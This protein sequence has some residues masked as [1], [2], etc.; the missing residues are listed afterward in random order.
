MDRHH[1]WLLHDY[2]QLSIYHEITWKEFHDLQVPKLVSDILV[3]PIK[4][5]ALTEEIPAR[6][7]ILSICQA[8]SRKDLKTHKHEM[9]IAISGCLDVELFVLHTGWVIIDQRGTPS[10]DIVLFHTDVDVEESQKCQLKG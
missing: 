10:Y 3:L 5:F 2:I 9:H 4:S 7:R 1:P 8:L 6:W